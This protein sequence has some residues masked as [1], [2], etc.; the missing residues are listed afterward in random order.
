MVA[1]GVRTTKSACALAEKHGVELPIAH[2]VRAVLFEGMRPEEALNQLLD[3]D[4]KPEKS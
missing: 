2:A 4:A 3:R 1:E